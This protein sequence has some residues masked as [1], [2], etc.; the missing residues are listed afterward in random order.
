MEEEVAEAVAAYIELESV[1]DTEL[2]VVKVRVA[3]VYLCLSVVLP[4]LVELLGLE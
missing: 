1:V 3:S 2:M 4:R